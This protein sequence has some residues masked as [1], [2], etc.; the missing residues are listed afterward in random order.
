[1]VKKVKTYADKLLESKK[2]RKDFEQK[3]K[4][5]VI[6]EKIAQKDQIIMLK[7]KSL[8]NHFRYFIKDED[9]KIT[10][11]YYTVCRK[12][13]SLGGPKNEKENS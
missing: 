5:L 2:F 3:Y 1:M 13:C 6:S 9:L 11:E 7:V 4:N 8:L 10:D 12:Y